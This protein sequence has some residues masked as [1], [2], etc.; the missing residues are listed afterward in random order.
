[1]TAASTSTSPVAPRNQNHNT[2][3][4]PTMTPA[5]NP[6][7]PMGSNSASH[8]FHPYGRHDSQGN[9]PAKVDASRDPRLKLRGNNGG[10]NGNGNSGSFIPAASNGNNGNHNSSEQ[11]IRNVINTSRDP[12]TRR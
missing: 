4:P 7:P 9:A 6:H 2:E 12:R 5:N 3:H 10:G 1:M 11:S 8:R